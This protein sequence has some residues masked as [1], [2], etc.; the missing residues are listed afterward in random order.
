MNQKAHYSNIPQ[1]KDIFDEK[2]NYL[3]S[4]T[5]VRSEEINAKVQPRSQLL[6]PN[7]KNADI[8]QKKDKKK[9]SEQ[10]TFYWYSMTAYL[11]SY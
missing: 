4:S 9:S 2:I 8:S 6:K 5:A 1:D 3:V 11:L 7:Q 10:Q